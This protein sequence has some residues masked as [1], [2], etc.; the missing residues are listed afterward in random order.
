MDSSDHLNSNNNVAPVL[1]QS[2]AERQCEFL[3]QLRQVDARLLDCIAQ[4]THSLMY[5]EQLVQSAWKLF[6]QAVRPCFLWCDQEQTRWRILNHQDW[7]A[8][9]ADA[10][11]HLEHVPQSLMTFVASPSR[12]FGH[13]SAISSRASWHHWHGFLAQHNLDHCALVSVPDEN[14]DWLTMC[15]FFET[16]SESEQSYLNWC[17]QQFLAS[18]PHWIN[19]LVVRRAADEKLQEHTDEQTG[20]LQPHAFQNGL[21]MMLR[22]A[23]RY[24]LRLAFATVTVKDELEA[25]ELKLLSDTLRSTLRDN[26]LLSSFGE[27]E[28]VMAMRIGQLDDAE[29]V[30]TKI[31]TALQETDPN[32]VSLLANGVSIGVA[33]YPEH[34]DQN[35]LYFASK[36]AAGAVTEKLG[37][38]LEYYGKFVRN[39]DEAYQE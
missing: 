18:L 22:D 7:Q 6:P 4:S 10:M 23:R 30:A 14:G 32:E 12:Q 13:E 9:M 36:A 21:G 15:L 37:Y 1:E 31:M 17:V 26:D 3:L 5:I 16:L 27:R 28:F 11:G 29:V 34:T 2:E 38:R 24:F 20:L 19:A 33:F 8:D 25:A 35:R 39:L